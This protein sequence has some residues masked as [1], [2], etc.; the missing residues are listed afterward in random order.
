MLASKGRLLHAIPIW[1]RGGVVFDPF[2]K[3]HL[4][5]SYIDIGLFHSFDRGKSWFHNVEGIPGNWVN[6]CYDV[7]FDP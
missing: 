5:I 1:A 7:T 4:I 3:N 6:T 2:D